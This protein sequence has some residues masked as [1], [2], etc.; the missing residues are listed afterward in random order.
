MGHKRAWQW[1]LGSVVILVFVVLC[2]TPVYAYY[3]CTQPDG[4]QLFTD[5]PDVDCVKQKEPASPASPSPE[6][7]KESMEKQT[8]LGTEEVPGEQLDF[9]GHNREWWQARFRDLQEKKNDLLLQKL[10]AK[11]RLDLVPPYMLGL[12]TG[13]ER[14]VIIE[15][16]DTLK[17]MLQIVDQTINSDLPEEARK[18]GAPP[19]WVR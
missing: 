8:P 14:M 11:R 3:I 9:N 18:A 6:K 13:S 16:I 12:S 1:G 19:G 10:D 7:R 15:E 5:Y 4:T 17:E 2:M